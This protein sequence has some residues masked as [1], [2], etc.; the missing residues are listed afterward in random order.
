MDAVPAQSA[1][2]LQLHTLRCQLQKPKIHRDN[3]RLKFFCF[4]SLIQLPN[5]LL[6]FFYFFFITRAITEAFSNIFTAF[7]NNCA[8]NHYKCFQI[9]SL[10][11]LPPFGST[12]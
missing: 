6:G 11:Q 12:F 1:Q 4:V 3:R 8:L 2:L 9:S 10:V 5:F 7:Q